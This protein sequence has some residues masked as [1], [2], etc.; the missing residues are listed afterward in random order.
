MTVILAQTDSKFLASFTVSVPTVLLQLRRLCGI[1][2]NFR[3]RD[4]EGTG[5][6][7]VCYVLRY[8]PST[9]SEK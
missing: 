6:L 3:F 5:L 1:D 2:D 9:L 4:M 7:P 8:C